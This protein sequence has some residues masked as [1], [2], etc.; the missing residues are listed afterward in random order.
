VLALGKLCLDMETSTVHEIT[1]LASQAFPQLKVQPRPGFV[2]LFVTLVLLFAID[3]STFGGLLAAHKLH[4]CFVFSRRARC[5]T[6][7]LRSS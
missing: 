5:R 4:V 1:N 6:R 2:V 7:K 3:F